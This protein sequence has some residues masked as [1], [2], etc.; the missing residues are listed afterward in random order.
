LE[1][2]KTEEGRMKKDNKM[3]VGKGN[4]GRGRKKNEEER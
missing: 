3:E 2:K 1:E 4:E